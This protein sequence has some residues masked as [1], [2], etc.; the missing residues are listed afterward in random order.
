M[1]E[2]LLYD[3]ILDSSTVLCKM[4]AHRCRISDGMCGQCAVRENRGGTLYSLNYGQLCASHIDPIEKK[5]LFH[6]LPG[7]YSLSIASMGCNFTCLHC[8]NSSISQYPKEHA[9]ITGDMI[10]PANVVQ[11][12][13]NGGCK[14]ISYTYTEPT[15]YMEYALECAIMAREKR[16]KNVFVSNGYMTTESARLIIP[17]LDADNIDLKGNDEFYKQ[18]CGGR[19]KPVKDTIMLMKERGVWVEV[20]TLI[21]P[22]LNDSDETLK[23]IA[24]FIKSV[25]QAI[26]W[27]VTSFRPTYKI[28]DR[29]VT[30][31]ATLKRA[32]R[33]GTE[34]GLKYVYE[35][36]VPGSS[37]ENTYCPS[38]RALLIERYGFSVRTNL[39]KDCKCP[40]CGSAIDGIWH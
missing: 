3:K 20:T 31:S 12:A 35:G 6:F 9:E 27:H 4:C 34:A 14:S 21:I 39:I 37:G 24:G 36:N 18:V 17:Y 38:C 7:S 19:V 15:I 22:G 40:K 10:V 32:Y 8:Q 5:P 16:I 29:P 1:K 13:I 2:A 23:D 25:D 33:I 26:P 30:P 11:G 28:P